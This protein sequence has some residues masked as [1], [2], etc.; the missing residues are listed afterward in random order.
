MFYVRS[1]F[2]DWLLMIDLKIHEAQ[3]VITQVAQN[4]EAN[5]I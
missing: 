3:I 5:K 2:V 4:A 1:I